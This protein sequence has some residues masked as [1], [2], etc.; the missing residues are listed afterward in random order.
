M[1]QEYNVLKSS[2]FD[3]LGL[4][5]ID[6][7]LKLTCSDEFDYANFYVVNTGSQSIKDCKV[8]FSGYFKLNYGS[9]LPQILSIPIMSNEQF[10][11]FVVIKYIVKLIDNIDSDFKN[12]IENA[13]FNE[14]KIDKI[15]STWTEIINA[16]G[17]ETAGVILFKNIFMVSPIAM[18]YFPESW[19]KDGEIYQNRVFR[20]HCIKVIEAVS[21]AISLLKDGAKLTQVLTELG[22]THETNGIVPDAYPIVGNAVNATI[23]IAMG[24]Q[25]TVEVLDTYTLFYN[26]GANLMIGGY[27]NKK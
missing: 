25:C 12:K 18:H 5:K 20:Q 9:T 10:L 1:G 27:L 13:K 8:L 6:Y 4:T 2:K 24:D 22:K 23:C 15:Q 3:K 7:S 21:A 14:K 16:V 17:K 26:T 19:K 11:G